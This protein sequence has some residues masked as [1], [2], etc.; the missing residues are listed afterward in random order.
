MKKQSKSRQIIYDAVIKC[1]NESFG[2][3]SEIIFNEDNLEDEININICKD[4]VELGYAILIPHKTISS[5]Y[6]EIADTDSYEMAE[7]VTFELN[8]NKQII[9]IADIDVN[10]K[11]R[12][13]GVSKKLIEYILEKF[14]DYQFY[15]RVCP[16]GGVDE[17]TF[18]NTFSRYG[19][20]FIGRNDENGTFMVKK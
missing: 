2:N 11:Y 19:F 16:T 4:G 13:S 9:E 15:V 3:D 14:K 7:D 6:S 8:R 1:L 10:K 5:L 17:Y 20:I 12:N 18:R